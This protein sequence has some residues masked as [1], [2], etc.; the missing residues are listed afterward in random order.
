[1]LQH[2]S[3]STTPDSVAPG[4]ETIAGVT[5]DGNALSVTE[6]SLLQ[7]G[8]LFVSTALQSEANEL[9]E[10][11]GS[12]RHPIHQPVYNIEFPLV[13]KLVTHLSSL[14]EQLNTSTSAVLTL[15][16]DTINR[17]EET[18]NGTPETDVYRRGIKKIR[19]PNPYGYPM[20]M[21]Y[22]RETL[23]QLDLM[24]LWSMRF[25][26]F[27]H[28]AEL[29]Y[30]QTKSFAGAVTGHR[31][32]REILPKILQVIP[33]QPQIIVHLGKLRTSYVGMLNGE[34]L[35]SHTIPVGVARDGSFY[36]EKLSPNLKRIGELINDLGSLILPADTT[37]T[38]IFNRGLLSPQSEATR[39]AHQIGEYAY[40]I[41]KDNFPDYDVNHV[42]FYLSG[43]VSRLKG[44]LEYQSEKTGLQFDFLSSQLNDKLVLT[45]DMD[46]CITDHLLT[47]GSCLSYLN[48]SENRSG[49]ILTDQRPKRL[50]SVETQ[51]SYLELRTPYIVEYPTEMFGSL[52]PSMRQA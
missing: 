31:A 17:W 25:D 32:L 11:V 29:F 33:N 52:T 18:L 47:M 48:R 35:F 1:M 51:N 27:L 24:Q 49:M 41:K 6:I 26:D 10:K 2:S 37:P 42:H 30:S 45:N 15:P 21:E 34:V 43:T 46:C 12:Y 13:E 3:D 36:F 50:K 39:F 9:L 14:L 16:E 8:R 4:I 44:L 19:H 40:K 22:N 20:L 23:N 7:D 5:L 28:M 38:R